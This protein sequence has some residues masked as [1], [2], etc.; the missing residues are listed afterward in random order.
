MAEREKP[1]GKP[2]QT[3]VKFT[4]LKSKWGPRMSAKIVP[5]RITRR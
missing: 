2:Q 1:D 5:C 4:S 3:V